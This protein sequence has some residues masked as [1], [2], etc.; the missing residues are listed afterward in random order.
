MC[1][2]HVLNVWHEDVIYKGYREVDCVEVRGPPTRAGCGSFVV[3][4]TVKLLKESN[5]FYEYDIILF[6]VLG[7]V[8]GGG[9]A[10]PLN[11]VD[12]CI[13]ITDNGF[14]ALFVDNCIATLV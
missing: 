13:I 10:V 11:Y 12:Y 8:I 5:S 9:F 2:F 7:N 6:D 1:A 4:E 3:R 14:D